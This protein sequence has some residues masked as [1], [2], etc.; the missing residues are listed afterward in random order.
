M[1]SGQLSAYTPGL[2][3]CH[4]S[5]TAQFFLLFE[6]WGYWF[7]RCGV[8]YDFFL[9]LDIKKLNNLEIINPVLGRLSGYT[10]VLAISYIKTS[11]GTCLRSFYV[12]LLE[13]QNFARVEK[14]TRVSVSKSVG[15]R[16]L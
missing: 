7:S 3:V 1:T 16:M 4:P 12:C 6:V 9:N 13:G 14:L 11:F 8:F 15:A 10:Q 2:Q 5:M